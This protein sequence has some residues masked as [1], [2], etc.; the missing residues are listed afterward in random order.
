MQDTMSKG[1]LLFKQRSGTGGNY[2]EK[3]TE[4]LI[5]LLT[6]NGVKSSFTWDEGV[7]WYSVSRSVTDFGKSNYIKLNTIYNGSPR[8]IAKIRVSDHSVGQRRLINEIHYHQLALDHKFRKD[9]IKS[10]KSW[11]K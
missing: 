11:M 5:K 3:H 10:I 2:T 1:S 7:V 6:K 9:F 4:S 8:E